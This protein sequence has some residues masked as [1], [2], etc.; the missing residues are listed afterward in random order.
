MSRT[1]AALSLAALA[2]LAAC[3]AEPTPPTPPPQMPWIQLFDG[4]GLGSFEPS[5]FGGDGEIAVRDGSLELGMGSPLTGVRWTGALPALPYELVCEAGRLDGT[6]FF[7]G[8]TFPVG[9]AALTLVLGGWGGAVCGLSS[10]DGLDAAHNSTRT[11]RRFEPGRVYTIALRVTA[12]RVEVKLDGEAFLIADL[13]GH[14]LSLRPEVELSRPLG[15]ATFLTKA[16][17]RALR[18]RHLAAVSGAP[19]PTAVPSSTRTR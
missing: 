13:R 15:I 5:V 3:A 17:V 4:H 6:D 14:R 9:D 1:V 16:T 19:Q 12:E 7:C 8:L 18:W 11:L 10:L 2:A